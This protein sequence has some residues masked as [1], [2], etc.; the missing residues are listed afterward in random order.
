MGQSPSET[1]AHGHQILNAAGADRHHEHREPCE[2]VDRLEWYDNSFQGRDFLSDHSFNFCRVQ[3]IIGDFQSLTRSAV[4]IDVAIFV[5]R[6]EITRVKPALTYC[7]LS[8]FG[9]VPLTFHDVVAAGTNFSHT[10]GLHGE[11]LLC[12]NLQSD[13]WNSSA[14]GTTTPPAIRIP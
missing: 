11:A 1:C 3:S 13:A 9:I 12:H 10:A 7:R 4:E 6:G 14:K 8:A 2:A 5:D